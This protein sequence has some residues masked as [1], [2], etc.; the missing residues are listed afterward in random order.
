M[1][2]SGQASG[3]AKRG[4]RAGKTVGGNGPVRIDETDGAAI[5]DSSL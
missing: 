4:W 1:K 3:N 2:M 5:M